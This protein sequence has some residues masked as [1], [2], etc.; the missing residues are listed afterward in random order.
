MWCS[1]G[2]NT[3]SAKQGRVGIMYDW[4]SRTTTCKFWSVSRVSWWCSLS[5]IT[6]NLFSRSK[7][8]FSTHSTSRPLFLF[9]VNTPSDAHQQQSNNY[10]ENDKRTTIFST[11][12]PQRTTWFKSWSRMLIWT[13]PRARNNKVSF[14]RALSGIWKF[15]RQL[16]WQN[17]SKQTENFFLTHLDC[18]DKQNLQQRKVQVV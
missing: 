11:Q 10:K 2:T 17:M 16:K 14:C 1:P 4:E 3:L 18:I 6:N 7:K 15:G 8:V 13:S 12:N 9:L 5:E